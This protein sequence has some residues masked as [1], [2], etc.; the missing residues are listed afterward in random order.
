[1][2]RP[3]VP[4]ALTLGRITLPLFAHASPDN[5]SAPADAPTATA[6]HH[7]FRTSSSFRCGRTRDIQHCEVSYIAYMDLKSLRDTFRQHVDPRRQSYMRTFRAL[8]QIDQLRSY[9]PFHYGSLGRQVRNRRRLVDWRA[10]G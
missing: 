6:D 7:F 3:P 1:M 8:G 2:P 9:Q 5:A 4:V 10:S